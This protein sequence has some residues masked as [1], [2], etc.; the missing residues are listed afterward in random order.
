[1]SNDATPN[2]AGIY[3]FE[4]V[5]DSE[6]REINTRREV[7]GVSQ[8]GEAQKKSD[9]LKTSLIGLALS[10]GGIRSA[11]FSLGVLQSLHRSGWLKWVDYLSTVSGGGFAGAYLSSSA[12][13]GTT[14]APG[15]Q[16]KAT[17]SPEKTAKLAGNRE[18]QR[19]DTVLGNQRVQLPRIRQ[20]LGS[21]GFLFDKILWLNRQLIGVILI[22]LVV[23]SG[24]VAVA[25]LMAYLFRNLDRLAIRQI[26]DGLGFRD[27]LVLALVPSAIL[28]VAYLFLWTL[29][30]WKYSRLASGRM[31]RYAMFGFLVVT[32]IAIAALI[33]NGEIDTNT[34]STWVIGEP[35]SMETRRKVEQWVPT[36]IYSFLGASLIPYL[37]PRRLFR[38]GDEGAG[39]LEQLTFGFASAALVYG[40]PFLLVAYFARE[41]VSLYSTRRIPLMTCNYF[42]EKRPPKIFQ[43][44]WTERQLYDELKS[45]GERKGL[46][47]YNIYRELARRANPV[48]SVNAP[49]NSKSKFSS[50]FSSD[51][52]TLA[53]I[54]AVA[55]LAAHQHQLKGP[56]ATVVLQNAFDDPHN[57]I[58]WL[59]RFRHFLEYFTSY[60]DTDKQNGYAYS[61][62]LKHQRTELRVIEL[63]AHTVNQLLI[64][65]EFHTW[66]PGMVT[67]PDT[68]RG[69]DSEWIVFREARDHAAAVSAVAEDWLR[70]ENLKCASLRQRNIG[71]GTKLAEK[72]CEEL[73]W[74]FDLTLTDHL[75]LGDDDQPRTQGKWA[76]Q[77]ESSQLKFAEFPVPKKGSLDAFKK[78]WNQAVQT[79]LSDLDHDGAGR[80]VQ[81]VLAQETNILKK[82]VAANRAVLESY[83]PNTLDPSTRVYSYVV[84]L[85]D[86]K[87]RW[88]WFIYSSI[89]FLIS[90]M[91]VDLNATSWHGYYSRQI[92]SA[93]IEPAPGLGRD[94]PLAQ[95]ETTW[96]GLPYHLISGTLNRFQR[97]LL[98]STQS[99]LFLFSRQFCGAVQT[100]F[101]KTESFEGGKFCLA[102]AIA[103]SGAAFSP[104]RES[105]PLRQALLY[106]SNFRLGQWVQNP[107]F[108]PS[109]LRLWEAIATRWPITPFTALWAMFQPNSVPRYVFVT[110]GGHTDNLA[111]ESLLQ[112]RA[113]I[114]VVIDATEDPDY[115]FTELSRVITSTSNAYG[116]QYEWLTPPVSPPPDAKSASTEKNEERLR[117]LGH[118][119][120]WWP[121]I[122]SI[123][124]DESKK[125]TIRPDAE[126]HW[127]AAR[128]IY[129]SKSHPAETGYFLYLKCNVCAT[130][131][132]ELVEYQR[133]HCPFPHHPTSD[134]VFDAERFEAYRRLGE[135][136]ANATVH[137]LQQLP[138]VLE[139]LHKH[140]FATISSRQQVDSPKAEQVQEEQVEKEDVA[141]EKGST[142]STEPAPKSDVPPP[143]LEELLQWRDDVYNE[144]KDPLD[145]D[146][147]LKRKQAVA[148][149]AKNPETAEAKE[150]KSY[151]EARLQ[152]TAPHDIEAIETQHLLLEFGNQIHSKLVA[153]VKQ[154]TP[155][156]LPS[157]V[158]LVQLA[159]LQKA[160]DRLLHIL[161]EAL[162]RDV[163]PSTRRSIENAIKSQPYNS[164]PPE[165][166]QEI[167]KLVSASK[168]EGEV[169]QS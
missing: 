55:E 146:R 119:K 110:D 122:P 53:E 31:A 88:N 4:E 34:I 76:A 166:W 137:D 16:G 160:N 149:L 8:R 20:L 41:N 138:A 2:S 64:R 99:A 50:M 87:T 86:Q 106:L 27:D 141:E 58:N 145:F 125:I 126:R 124:R 23:V 10:G 71:S 52:Q 109:R 3:K 91:C 132:P 43:S 47:G 121:V 26:V 129:E 67:K 14:P 62:R 40:V 98:N 57:E 56:A 115:R 72:K 74:L 89:I 162:T 37:T 94:I 107:Q 59:R 161:A 25:S 65:P 133:T 118:P 105:N 85:E 164:Y 97:D 157:V 84:L 9:C 51:S 136:A 96:H 80:D 82:V 60:P 111:I 112:R 102:D 13:T 150:A 140:G 101:Q 38:S 95:L 15:E 79:G 68:W 33:G 83:Y 69:T 127:L 92:A 75:T 120:A 45:P 17:E 73:N 104:W 29:S 153:E 7:A 48:T 135:A 113:K 154:A 103:V 36:L 28:L 30:Y 44:I 78:N 1:M 90:G 144:D 63:Q 142:H 21:G 167:A 152:F 131:P 143:R 139:E 46:A 169:P 32:S 100:G 168:N 81:S 11:A 123:E 114:I 155:R 156:E 54:E 117:S 35:L 159:L 165:L 24:L 6:L 130:D 128:I 39:S 147:W 163:K 49:K 108:R 151:L 93:W 19:L 42:G 77:E 158:D 12:L 116:I 5:F 134:L 70:K 61:E 22:W 66:F 18:E 148:E